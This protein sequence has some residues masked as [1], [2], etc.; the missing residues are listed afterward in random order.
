MRV[1]ST[2][3]NGHKKHE[4]TQKIRE[5]SDLFSSPLLCFFVFFVAILCGLCA[6][7]SQLYTLLGGLALEHH[8]AEQ[9]AQRRADVAKVAQERVLRHTLHAGRPPARHL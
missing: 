8:T 5:N 9:D 4:K 6:P 1:V 3:E 7:I 2:Q